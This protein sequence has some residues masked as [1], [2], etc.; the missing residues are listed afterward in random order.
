MAPHSLNPAAAVTRSPATQSI[1]GTREYRLPAARRGG[2]LRGKLPGIPFSR[3]Y[4]S[5]YGIQPNST[6]SA[7]D[8]PDVLDSGIALITITALG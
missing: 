7:N 2:G 3:N 1:N 6:G 8:S 5:N 4:N